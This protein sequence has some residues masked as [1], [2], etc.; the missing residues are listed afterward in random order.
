MKRGKGEVWMKD[1]GIRMK[2][3]MF[4]GFLLAA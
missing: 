4:V 2:V 3:Y 1:E